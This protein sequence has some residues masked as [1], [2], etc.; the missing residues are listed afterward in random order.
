MNCPRCGAPLR[1]GA[2]FCTACGT[3]VAKLKST[4]PL[5]AQ[6][7]PE[8][9]PRPAAPEPAEETRAGT[10]YEAVERTARLVEDAAGPAPAV[11]KGRRWLRVKAALAVALAVCSLALIF[12]PWFRAGMLVQVDDVSIRSQKYDLVFGSVT[13][14][15]TPLSVLDVMQF[16]EVTDLVDLSLRSD[17]AAKAMQQAGWNAGE[18]VR[19]YLAVPGEL[20]L[21][22]AVPIPTGLAVMAPQLLCIALM[23]VCFILG[24]IRAVAADPLPDGAPKTGWLMAGGIAGVVMSAV[25]GAEM[26]VVNRSFGALAERLQS[27]DFHGTVELHVSAMLCYVLF[28]AASVLLVVLAAHRREKKTIV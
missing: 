17:D 1:E 2:V 10:V 20:R 16:H 7:A 28:A 21:F 6:P 15:G 26:L 8:A 25:T 5:D 23:V 19:G 13:E 14:R 24:V 3:R 18:R 11:Q 4:I 9:A 22:G 27:A 12:F